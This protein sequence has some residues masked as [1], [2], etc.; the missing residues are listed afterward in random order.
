MLLC[1]LVRDFIS[2]QNYVKGFHLGASNK[3]PQ[4]DLVPWVDLQCVIVAFPGKSC[5]PFQRNQ[6]H[7]GTFYKK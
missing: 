2:S 5:T 1:K 4:Y 7:L 3:Y 6:E